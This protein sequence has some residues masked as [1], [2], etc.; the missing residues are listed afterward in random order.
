ME[1]FKKVGHIIAT[2]I[3]TAIIAWIISKDKFST[4][5]AY[6]NQIQE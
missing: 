6:F 2:A 5:K 4:D 1:H 3:I